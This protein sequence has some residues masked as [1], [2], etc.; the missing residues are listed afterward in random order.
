MFLH[1]FSA[2]QENLKPKTAIDLFDDEEEED[3]DIFSDKYSAAN[4]NQSKKEVVEKTV[5]T[6]EKKVSK[7]MIYCC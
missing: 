2:I 4:A 1:L 7:G 5:K 6:P 3:G